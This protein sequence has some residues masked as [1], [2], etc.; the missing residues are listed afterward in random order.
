[1]CS[2]DGIK[3]ISD[4]KCFTKG[5]KLAKLLNRTKVSKHVFFF[6]RKK[7]SCWKLSYI[8]FILLCISISEEES[9]IGNRNTAF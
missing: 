7:N 6:G 3:I 5:I 1:M 2:R 4:I 8:I 9:V